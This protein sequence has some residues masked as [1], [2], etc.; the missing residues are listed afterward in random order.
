MPNS[1]EVIGFEISV[2]GRDDGTLEAI[3]IRFQDG[4]VSET[5]E[6]MDDV[7]L[8]DYDRRGELLGIEILAPVKISDLMRLVEE[9]RKRP[10]RKFIK[11]T[12]PEEFVHA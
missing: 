7:L 9:P 4:T 5:K 3:Y 2:S 6:I 10:F 1:R 11:Q 8:A 12:A